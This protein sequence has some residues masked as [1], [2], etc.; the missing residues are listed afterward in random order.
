M[1]VSGPVQAALLLIHALPVACQQE[2]DRD[3]VRSLALYYL[4][5]WWGTTI[6]AV[7]T[8]VFLR[9][10]RVKRRA[11]RLVSK[12]RTATAAN[13]QWCEERTDEGGWT[14]QLSYNFPVE[15][16]A[17]HM[18][19]VEAAPVDTANGV[20]E[21]ASVLYLADDPR[22]HMGQF[23]AQQRVAA[24]GVSR[25]MVVFFILAHLAGLVLSFVCVAMM[26]FWDVDHIAGSLTWWFVGQL[27]LLPPW[28][29]KEQGF[30]ACGSLAC[31]PLVYDVYPV[32]ALPVWAFN[33]YKGMHER[34]GNDSRPLGSVVPMPQVI[35]SVGG[36]ASH[37]RQE[38][39]KDE[40]PD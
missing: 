5:S 18:L 1:R 10:L 29:P 34:A 6:S 8:Y 17:G 11:A 21:G 24:G 37:T 33:F 9:A 12:G 27:P 7:A 13:M 20:F 23:E 39:G 28:G 22:V 3:K 4:F 19:K 30:P 40:D 32:A 15:E 31:N 16:P 2:I 26:S 35:G 25:N 38:S 36:E 14:T